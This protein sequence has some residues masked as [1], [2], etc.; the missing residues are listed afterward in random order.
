MET[1]K[2]A[3]EIVETFQRDGALPPTAKPKARVCSLRVERLYNLGNYTSVKY[4]IGVDVPEGASAKEALLEVRR[5]LRYLVPKRAE[6]WP[7][8]RAKELLDKFAADPESLTVEQKDGLEDA[9]NL[10]AEAALQKQLRQEA[11]RALDDLGGTVE[12]RDAKTKW[13]DDD[14]DEPPF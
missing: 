2:T 9:K 4:S 1:E 10:L 8:T 12:N 5:I 13:E 3:E 6:E 7:L 11:L 14:S